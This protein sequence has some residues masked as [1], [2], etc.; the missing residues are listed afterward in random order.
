MNLSYRWGEYVP[1]KKGLAIKGK[2]FLCKT[3][4]VVYRISMKEF[5]GTYPL[6]VIEYFISMDS[7]N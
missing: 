6:D 4:I 3:E 2:S 5:T 1:I 7:M